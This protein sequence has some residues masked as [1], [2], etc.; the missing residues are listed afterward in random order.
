MFG[1]LILTWSFS[2]LFSS[3]DFFVLSFPLPNR[4]P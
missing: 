2:F 4:E 1:H 3:F